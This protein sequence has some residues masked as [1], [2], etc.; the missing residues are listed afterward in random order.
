MDTNLES[1][2]ALC[3]AFYPAL[4]RS[5]AAAVVFNSSVASLVSMQSGVV[6]AM[7]KSAM[8]MLTKYLAC[9]WAPDGIRV[10]AVAPWY[11]NTPLAKQVLADPRY[12]KAVVSATPAGRVGEPEEVG[13]ATAFLCMPASSYVTG[14]VLAVDGGSRSTDGNHR[15]SAN[16]DADGDDGAAGRVR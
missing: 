13:T 11:I 9:E 7:T 4:C 2:F 3:Q 10:N 15:S 6:Y 1:S 14:Q 12:A 5:G 8:N 16:C